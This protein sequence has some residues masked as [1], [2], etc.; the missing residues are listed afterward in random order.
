M[1]TIAPLSTIKSRQA[2]GTSQVLNSPYRPPATRPEALKF[3]QGTGGFLSR[4]VPVKEVVLILPLSSGGTGLKPDPS[5]L[6]ATA[7]GSPCSATGVG[8]LNTALRKQKQLLDRRA[9]PLPPVSVPVISDVSTG[10]IRS[11]DGNAGTLSGSDERRQ[12]AP[13]LNRVDFFNALRR[14]AGLA[15]TPNTVH[16]MD[17][18][19][20]KRNDMVNGKELGNALPEESSHLW[21]DV[22][23]HPVVDSYLLENGDG[24]MNDTTLD[25]EGPCCNVEHFGTEGKENGE[26]TNG[27]TDDQLFKEADGFLQQQLLQ[28]EE[29]EIPFLISLGWNRAKVEAT[30][31]LTQDEIDAFIQKVQIYLCSKFRS[32][33]FHA[34]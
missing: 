26:I 16:K 25:A 33:V 23:E 2:I 1:H 27:T 29:V 30:D 32:L 31:A 6:V 24:E 21:E 12:T 13:T 3:G 18:A 14:K 11:N 10:G 8:V 17:V 15:G 4:K 9:V 20:P 19:P 22:R 28:G 7:V 34:S 5:P